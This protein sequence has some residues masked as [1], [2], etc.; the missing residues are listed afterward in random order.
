MVNQ[1]R[2]AIVGLPA[3]PPQD[4][5]R[6]RVLT[7]LNWR[8]SRRAACRLFGAVKALERS[9]PL[10]LQTDVST[11]ETA[12]LEKAQPAPKRV[13]DGCV[14][15]RPA[16]RGRWREATEGAL[17]ASIA[18]AERNT[19]SQ[20]KKWAADTTSRRDPVLMEFREKLTT[21]QRPFKAIIIAVARKLLTHLNA[22]IRSGQPWDNKMTP[23]PA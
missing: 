11:L 23:I 15:P 8:V 13:Q 9:V 22:I 7:R 5:L 1:N 17:Y 19:P 6:L 4:T 10:R 21:L 18:Q 14:F 12:P 20:N 16:K 2:P 3:Q